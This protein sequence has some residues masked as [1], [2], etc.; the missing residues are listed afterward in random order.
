ML[1]YLFELKRQQR[2]VRTVSKQQS[3]IQDP[4]RVPELPETRPDTGVESKVTKLRYTKGEA[5]A[6]A[7][8]RSL[9]M[10]AVVASEV[11]ALLG[12]STNLVRKWVKD[13][14]VKAPTYEVPY[15]KNKIYLFTPED[16]EEL[17]DHL[18]RQRTAVV[19]R[20]EEDA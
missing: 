1:D 9:G 19:R 18:A 11:A 20:R 15:G 16:V 4:F 2:G 14:A 10:D 5:P 17:R 6:T 3:Y 12:V 13:P 8:V 7:Y